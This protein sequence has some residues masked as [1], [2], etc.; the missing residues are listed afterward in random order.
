MQVNLPYKYSQWNC[1]NTLDKT[2]RMPDG[3]RVGRGS[4]GLVVQPTR[5][6]IEVIVDISNA[7]TTCAE[8]F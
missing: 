4:G 2:T 5:H 7:A 1:E 6:V 8:M 3:Q